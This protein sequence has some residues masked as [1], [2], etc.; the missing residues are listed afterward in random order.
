[1]MVKGALQCVHDTELHENSNLVY[2]NELLLAAAETHNQNEI[3]VV[4]PKESID[5]C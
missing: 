3:K 1:M 5:Q 2:L 4:L